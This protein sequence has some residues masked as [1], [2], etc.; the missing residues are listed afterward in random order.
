MPGGDRRTGTVLDARAG[1][2]GAVRRRE[3]RSAGCEGRGISHLVG[4]RVRRGLRRAVV[5]AAAA[6]AA[7]AVVPV[8]RALVRA[9][10]LVVGRVDEPDL[11]GRT[12]RA[13]RCSTR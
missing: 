4:G 2:A 6:A 1:P 10:A 5:A 12:C 7:L 13:A 9:G 3:A 11:R 8:A